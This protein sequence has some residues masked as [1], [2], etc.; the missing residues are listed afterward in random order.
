MSFNIASASFLDLSE[1]K[2]NSFADFT[3]ALPEDAGAPEDFT[4]GTDFA[5]EAGVIAGAGELAPLPPPIFNL[6][7]RETVASFFSDGGSAAGAGAGEERG[8]EEPPPMF[9]LM[10][11]AGGGASTAS[12]REIG[13]P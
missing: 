12:G 2:L 9:N 10:V 1:V 13:A 4:V 11:G 6:M 3:T 5:E 8:A 7:V